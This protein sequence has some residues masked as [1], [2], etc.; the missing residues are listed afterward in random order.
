[1]VGIESLK[2]VI[3][4]KVH[5]CSKFA[6]RLSQRARECQNRKAIIIV[7]MRTTLTAWISMFLIPVSTLLV[8]M[9]NYRNKLL[10]NANLCKSIQFWGSNMNIKCYRLNSTNW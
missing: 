4:Q 9:H 1:L 3:W 2:F 8:P 5:I 10:V 7:P 6:R